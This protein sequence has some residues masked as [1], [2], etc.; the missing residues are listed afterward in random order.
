MNAPPATIR[1][2]RPV[3]TLLL[4]CA[5]H[6]GCAEAEPISPAA[7]AL[8]MLPD[9]PS[10]TLAGNLQS[11]SVKAHNVSID[12]LLPA[13]AQ[14]FGF[15]LQYPI[16]HGAQIS[17]ALHDMPLDQILARILRNH[18]FAFAPHGRLGGAVPAPSS[19]KLW[20][21]IEPGQGVAVR[22]PATAHRK[23]PTDLAHAGDGFGHP[24]PS[25]RMDALERLAQAPS[26]T[27]LAYLTQ[28]LADPNVYVRKTALEVAAG[29]HNEGATRLIVNGL[30]D[31]DAKVRE[32]A[33]ELLG[34]VPGP[35]ADAGLAQARLDPAPA[36][37]AAATEHFPSR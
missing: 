17:I 23:S 7:V 24:T 9:G 25:V 1:L 3:A 16:P 11:A 20:V 27:A 10:I 22:S 34:E 31:K 18:G 8:R 33:A 36:V 21:W 32:L 12:E 26:A 4:A 2:P 29:W 6:I 13:L 19:G 15:S 14:T 35:A 37:R 5:L 30:N 28:A